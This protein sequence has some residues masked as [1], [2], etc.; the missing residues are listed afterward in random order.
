LWEQLG[1]PSEFLQVP[2]GQSRYHAFRS[3]LDL[4]LRVDEDLL[5]V[6]RQRND[7]GGLVLGHAASGANL[8]FVGR[9]ASSRLHLEE[10]LTLYDPIS[11]RPLVHQA[12]ATPRWYPAETLGLSCASLVI[13]T[14]HRHRTTRQSLRP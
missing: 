1:S 14:R 12:G 9:F 11:H 4:A 8:M 10:V 13:Q 7:P 5:R 3:E 2:Y 6:S